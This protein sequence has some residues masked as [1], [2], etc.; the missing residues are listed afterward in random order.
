[1]TFQNHRQLGVKANGREWLLSTHSG[2]SRGAVISQKPLFDVPTKPMVIQEAVFGDRVKSE[3]SHW[4][5]YQ[6]RVR[7]NK[8]KLVG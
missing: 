5:N 4:D 3:K 1:M 2:L 7:F 6:T 8:Q